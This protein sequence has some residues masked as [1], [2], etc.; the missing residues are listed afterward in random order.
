MIYD[1]NTDAYEDRDI[2]EVE[3]A[4][5]MRRKVTIYMLLLM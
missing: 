5:A 1:D 2:Y 3:R 4:V